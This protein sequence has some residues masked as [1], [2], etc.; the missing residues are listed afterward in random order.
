MKIVIMSLCLFLIVGC[1]SFTNYVNKK[2]DIKVKETKALMV[3]DMEKSKTDFIEIYQNVVLNISDTL[4]GRKMQIFY[5]VF[6]ETLNFIDSLKTEMNKLNE[7][8]L[9]NVEFIKE[10][11]LSKGV[12]DTLFNKLKLSYSLAMDIALTEPKKSEIKTSRDKILNEPNTDQRKNQYFSL[13]SPNGVSMILYGME[14]ELLNS[15]KISFDG[16][17]K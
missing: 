17:K 10:T 4:K 2:V 8:D 15:G 1:D 12:G 5:S 11:F 3:A 13:N 9:N 6:M 16:Y 14:C 7:S